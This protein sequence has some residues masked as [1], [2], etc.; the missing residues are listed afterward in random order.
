MT[1][2]KKLRYIAYLRRSEVR[3]D[4]QV[5]SIPAQK[6]KIKEQFP[7]LNIIA[8]REEKR[9]AFTPGR[10]IWNDTLDDILNGKA[11]GLVGWHPNRFSRNEIDTANL[12]YALRGPLKDLKFCSYTFNNGPEGVMFLQMTMNQSQYESAKQGR[13][14]KRGMEEK[15]QGGERPGKVMPGYMKLAV[16]DPTT[17]KPITYKDGKVKTETVEDPDRYDTIKKLLKHFLD[18]RLRPTEILKKVNEEYHFKT[19]YYRSRTDNSLKGG[20]PMPK[21]MLYRILRSPF[22]AGYYEHNGVLCKGNYEPLITWEEYT[23]IQELLGTKGNHRIGSFE[24]AF[25]QMIYCGECGCKVQSAHRTKYIKSEGKYATWV[26]YYCSRKSVKRPCTQRKYTPVEEVERDIDKELA[27]YTIHPDFKDLALRVLRKN[28]KLEASERKHSYK[29]L[30]MLREEKQ[31]EYDG[32]IDYLHRELLDEDEY[33]R[34]KGKLKLELDNLDRQLRDSEKQAEGSMVINEKAFNFAVNARVRFQKG[35]VRTKRDILRTLGQ[36]LMLKD[37]KLYIEPNEWLMPLAETYPEIEKN[38]LWVITK[39][40][41][42]S[43][44]LEQAMEPILQT[45]R[46][47]WDSNPRHPA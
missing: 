16:N 21:S 12:T 47:Q 2:N 28:H 11:E 46:A 29:R 7:G 8:W 6:R 32:L 1:D 3:E 25:S 24:Y 17:G 38:Y 9:S 22:Y 40:K 5:L 33:R 26:Y 18:D 36:N 37:N 39:H 44:Q 20:N 14:V 45:W 10:P 34:K 15:A 4:Y 23:L 43:K 30:H 35:D 13:D 31:D 19:S 27:K 42:N 41:A